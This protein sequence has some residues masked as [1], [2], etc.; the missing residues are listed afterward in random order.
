MATISSNGRVAYVY[1]SADST[2]YPVAGTTNTAANFDWTGDHTF[3]ADSDVRF[4]KSVLA[5][6]G[7]NI[8]ATPTERNS[9]ISA[10]PSTDGIVIFLKQDG[11]GNTIN[12]I[13]YSHNGTWHNLFGQ[14]EVK[15]VSSSTSYNFILSDAGKTLEALPNSG[16]TMSM[17]IPTEASANWTK[18]QRI[19]IVRAGEGVVSIAPASGVT[20]TSKNNNRQ[21]AA[22]WSAAVL[23]YRGSNAWVLIGDLTASA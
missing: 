7:I 8:F 12:Q 13:Q 11:N 23:Y 14:S 21:I 3:G 2:W 15:Q 9:A 22:Q 19:E 18:G 10:T 6:K 20:L 17:Q 4:A 1:D 16:V 5:T